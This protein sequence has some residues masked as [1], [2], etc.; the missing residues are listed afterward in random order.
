MQF[1]GRLFKDLGHKNNLLVDWTGKQLGQ[2]IVEVVIH[3]D[4]DGPVHP[5]V[6]PPAAL[7]R[8]V[9]QGSADGRSAHH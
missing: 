9:H 1:I 8:C 5:N 4:D 7:V 6:F 2:L 3:R